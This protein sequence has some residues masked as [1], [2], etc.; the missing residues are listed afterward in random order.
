MGPTVNRNIWRF[1]LL[2]LLQVLILKRISLGGPSFNYVQIFIYPLFLF[3]LPISLG[4]G[5]LLLLGLLLGLSIDV[6]Y[7]T[8]GLHGSAAVFTAFIRPFVLHAMEP[9]GGYKVQAIPTLAEFGSNWFYRYA[10][11]LLAAHS[12][13]YFMVEAFQVSEILFV[14]LK[15]FLAFVASMLLIVI[16]MLIFTPK[17]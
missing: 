4:R 10:G 16:Y 14:L 9:R 3:L 17:Y 8:P 2:L 11:I 12:F 13:L 6:F 7:D 1:I 15:T 5:W